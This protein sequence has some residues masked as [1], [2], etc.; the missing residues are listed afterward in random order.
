V[1]LVLSCSFTR[2]HQAAG[3][4]SQLG[5]R[6][7]EGSNAP[8]VMWAEGLSSTQWPPR[9]PVSPVGQEDLGVGA[10]EVPRRAP[11]RRPF[12]NAAG[13]GTQWDPRREETLPP[14]RPSG[15]SRTG[16]SE[17]VL[18]SIQSGVRV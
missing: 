18:G 6:P 15:F 16:L 1:Q 13:D 4:P 10:Q 17:S 3:H 7:G 12:L 9:P 5:I 11:R 14:F 2:S 8:E